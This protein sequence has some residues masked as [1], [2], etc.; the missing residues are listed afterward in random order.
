M[1]LNFLGQIVSWAWII[2]VCKYIQEV[3][4]EL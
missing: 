4:E 1:L 2:V 3:I